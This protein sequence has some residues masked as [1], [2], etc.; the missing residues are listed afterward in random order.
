VMGWSG[1]GILMIFG[2]RLARSDM[3]YSFDFAGQCVGKVLKV[4]RPGAARHRPL[5]CTIPVDQA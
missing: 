1:P 4:I 5:R 2:F 3:A